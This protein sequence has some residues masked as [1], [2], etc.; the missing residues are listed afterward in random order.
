MTNF[1]ELIQAADEIAEIAHHGQF[2]KD[3]RTPY[4]V[5][6][7]Q[8]AALG[9]AIGLD[10]LAIAVLKVHDVVEDT[11][12]SLDNVIDELDKRGFNSSNYPVDTF[13]E[14]LDA[15]TKRKAQGERHLAYLLRLRCEG[16]TVSLMKLVDI[17]VNYFDTDDSMP[18]IRD[19]ME[20]SYEIINLLIGVDFSFMEAKYD[21][22]I[23]GK[24]FI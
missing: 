23:R 1:K 17:V 12:L 21:H 3:G 11:N 7:R 8:A 16:K 5:H 13:R 19:K 10:G 15:L 18:K 14:Y 2:R 22:C 6:P 9:E 4:I 24:S 20:L